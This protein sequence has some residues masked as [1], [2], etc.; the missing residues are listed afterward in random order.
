MMDSSSQQSRNNSTTT[1]SSTT[2]VQQQCNSS[3]IVA[4]VVGKTVWT[5]VT[6]GL[7]VLLK[8]RMYTMKAIRAVSTT[9]CPGSSC[10]KVSHHC[11]YM[12]GEF[13]TYCPAD[14]RSITPPMV[15]TRQEMAAVVVW[16]LPFVVA[17]KR[18][19][20]RRRDS[21]RENAE[22][23]FLYALQYCIPVVY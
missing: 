15:P 10:T 14:S 2:A 16:R 1:D 3:M 12:R 8:T 6:F 9:T 11:R 5:F 7:R 4:V 22:V 23:F 18:G 20:C 17:G 13:H 21:R 19:N